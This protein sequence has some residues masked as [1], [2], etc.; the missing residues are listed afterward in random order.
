MLNSLT[1]YFFG[2]VFHYFPHAHAGVLFEPVLYIVGVGHPSVIF[3]AG[4][5]TGGDVLF[6]CGSGSDADETHDFLFAV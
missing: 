3:K 1:G 2:D 6:K 5:H 4:G